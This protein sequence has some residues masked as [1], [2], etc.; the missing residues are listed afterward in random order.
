[1]KDK[2]RLTGNFL[3]YG[4]KNLNRRIYTKECAEKM[5]EEF[6]TRG[7]IMYGELGQPEGYDVR[8][9]NVSHI[10]EEIHLDEEKNSI[11]GTITILDTPKG[12]IVKKLLKQDIGLSCRSRGAGTVNENG[13][14]EDYQLFSFDLI[15]D[16]DAFENIAPDDF[17]N[18]LTKPDTEE[19]L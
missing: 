8:L 7:G 9:S 15:A 2:I 16:Q 18:F 6:N 17:L 4:Q 13:E 11:V 5:V 3:H 19:K 10:V 14:I 12:K 1:M